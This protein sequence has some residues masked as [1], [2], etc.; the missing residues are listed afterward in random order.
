M[1]SRG[2][3]CKDIACVLNYD[4]AKVI[5]DHI[6]KI[7][8]VGRAGSKGK[9]YTLMAQSDFGIAMQIWKCMEDNGDQVPDDLKR[10]AYCR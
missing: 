2:I 10:L 1:M 9:A 7:G 6:H 5:D 3:D 4:C 8:R